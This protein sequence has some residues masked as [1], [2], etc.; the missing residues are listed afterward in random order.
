MKKAILFLFI[1]PL[2]FSCTKPDKREN[3][4]HF[5]INEIKIP[6]SP[7]QL[8]SYPVQSNFSQKGN[9]ILMGYNDKRH[10]LDFFNL[11]QGE[12]IVSK[13]LEFEGPSGIGKIESIFVQS[14]DSIFV[15]ELGKLHL[16]NSDLSKRQSWDLFQIYGN[17][18]L[19]VPHCNF[20]FKLY[21]DSNHKSVYFFM[22]QMGVSPLEIA[23]LPLMTSLNLETNE[24]IVLPI[25]HSEYFKSVS[26]QVGF[27]TYL[28]FYGKLDNQLI[29]NYQYESTIYGFQLNDERLTTTSSSKV[30]FVPSIPQTN[31]PQAYDQHAIENP[32]YLS[33]IPDPWR[34]LIYSIVWDGPSDANSYKTYL[35]KSQVLRV[36]NKDLELI[37]T[38]PL[39]DRTYQINNWFVNE[40]GL[41]L[42]KAHPGDSLLNE[43]FLMFDV[44]KIED[45]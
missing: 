13:K 2:Y 22:N 14:S 15:Y 41:Y 4:I 37:Q 10:S 12:V 8:S 38:I 32:Y 5:S 35:D 1:I 11:N 34:N 39:P 43:D 9:S 27:M 6:V 26:G 40:N 31:D 23:K 33:P 30:E 3:P 21:Y 20:Y 7:N 28:G 25:Y 44:F 18:N 45:N 17:L 29:F 36:F 42:N 24:V 16:L 19:G